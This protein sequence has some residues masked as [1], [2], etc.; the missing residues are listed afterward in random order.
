MNFLSP[1][2]KPTRMPGRLERF[3]SDWNATTRVKS[4]PAHSSALPGASRV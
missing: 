4:G 2:A 3:D 1:A